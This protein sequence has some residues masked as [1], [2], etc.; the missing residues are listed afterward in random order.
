MKTNIEI[1]KY[2]LASC[3]EFKNVLNMF[4]DDKER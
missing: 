3:I 1:N 2:F 4:A